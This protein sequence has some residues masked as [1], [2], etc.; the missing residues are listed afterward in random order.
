MLTHQEGEGRAGVQQ[1][2]GEG[3]GQGDGQ[4]GKR[5]SGPTGVQ[6]T[7]ALSG[8][9]LAVAVCGVGGRVVLD[10]SQSMPLADTVLLT[11]AR[12]RP[13]PLL[14]PA[15]ERERERERPWK[16]RVNVVL[17]IIF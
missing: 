16:C 6:W 14:C 2:P 13:P 3:E 4:G 1:W 12:S 15:S 11:K 5:G 17:S 10:S 8:Q 7:A 9:V